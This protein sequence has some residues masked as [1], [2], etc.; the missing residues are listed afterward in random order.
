[1]YRQD[2]SIELKLCTDEKLVKLFQCG[3]TEV[4]SELVARYLWLV[5]LK[6]RSFREVFS[7]EQ[8]DL[9][10]EGLLGLFDAASSF[11][12]EGKASFETFAGI[13]IHNRIV[14]AVRRNE[15]KKNSLL[16]HAVSMEALP[17]ADIKDTVDPL[18][19]IENR[20]ELE[21][22]L[23]KLQVYLS[24]FEQRVL[25]LYLGGYRRKEIKAHLNITEKA[26]D[27][28]MFRIRHKLRQ[29]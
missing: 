17:I 6:A 11:C 5:R 29:K 27:N 21:H 2:P 1:M 20:D 13:C 4:F 25:N 16:N 24:P 12:A 8:E 15:S 23:K 9:C 22:V 26:F 14:S 19:L 3:N 18:A 10:Q 7:L 28:A